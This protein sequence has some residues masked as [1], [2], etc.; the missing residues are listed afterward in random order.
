MKP[1]VASHRPFSTRIEPTIAGKI[2][3]PLGV[4]LATIAWTA[5]GAANLL[6]ATVWALIIVDAFAGLLAARGL[7]I[8]PPNID[9]TFAGDLRRIDLIVHATPGPF[10][11]RAVSLHA[12]R[13]RGDRPAGFE[14]ALIRGDQKRVIFANRWTERGA[15]RSLKLELATAHPLGILRVRKRFDLPV[16][17]LVLPK[18]LPIADLT[19]VRPLYGVLASTAYA[20]RLGDEEFHSLHAWRPG[21]S[22]RRV[23]WKHSARRGVLY[24]R[25]HEGLGRPDMR[26]VLET[27]VVSGDGA[28]RSFERAVRLLASLAA[29]HLRDGRSVRL[30]I[31]TETMPPMRGRNGLWPLLAALALAKSERGPSVAARF[32]PPAKGEE[33]VLVL[34]GGGRG[35]HDAPQAWTVF[36]VDAPGSDLYLARELQGNGAA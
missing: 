14:A 12:D 35:M 34:A 30:V 1:A 4:S 27:R 33:L 17:V 13:S 10:A 23:H 22:M 31:G 11:P 3:L 18:P 36:D 15:V 9:R 26:L 25:E 7:T 5:G 21:E 29:Y 16:D 19:L 2:L 28:L 32:D 24:R 6:A 8:D 20:R